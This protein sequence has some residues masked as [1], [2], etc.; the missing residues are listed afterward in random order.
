MTDPLTTQ[1]PS[2]GTV[3]PSDSVEDVSTSKRPKLDSV[4]DGT[5]FFLENL[6]VD[7]H[8]AVPR[9]DSMSPPVT[10][11]D[12]LGIDGPATTDLPSMAGVS[13][14]QQ[15]PAGLNSTPPP[16]STSQPRSLAPS[17]SLLAQPLSQQQSPATSVSPVAKPT[18]PLQ[19]NTLGGGRGGGGLTTSTAGAPL[20]T[21][22]VSTSADPTTA[23]PNIS[24][25]SAT[26]VPYSNM[27]T[28]VS[29]A[30]GTPRMPSA[31]STPFSYN[32][33]SGGMTSVA[34][35]MNLRVGMQPRALVMG[36]Y[37]RHP[38]PSQGMGGAVMPGQQM[39]HSPNMMTQQ[40]RMMTRQRKK[41]HPEV[42][43]GSM[44]STHPQRS[45]GQNVVLPPHSHQV[46]SQMM[47]P[48]ILTQQQ[49]MPVS[50]P[51][52][53]QSHPAQQPC[54][55]SKGV[56]GEE[57]PLPG[58]QMVHSPNMMTQQHRMMTRQRKKMHPEVHGGPMMST[59][60]QQSMGQNAV[61]PPHSHQ[62][63]SQMMAPHM[64]TRQ[65]QMP[66]SNPTPRQSH[67]SQQPCPPSKGVAGEGSPLPGQLGGPQ[68]H[69]AMPPQSQATPTSQQ[70]TPSQQPV[71]GVT[72]L[73][74]QQTP[75]TARPATPQTQIQQHLNALPTSAALQ[76]RS[77]VAMGTAQPVRQPSPSLAAPPQSVTIPQ[78]QTLP[79]QLSVPVQLPTQS[80][81]QV[82]PP[83]PLPPLPPQSS[84]GQQPMLSSL[85]GKG[86]MPG[87]QPTQQ[88]QIG[89]SPHGP[90]GGVN[91]FGAP[92]TSG[93][94]GG[95]NQPATM[96][97]EKRK[98]I[99]QQL[100][101]LLH[102]RYCQQKE[103]EHSMGGG[104]YQP[105]SVLHCQTMKNVLDHMTQCQAGRQ[106]TYDHC[107]SSR[108]IISHW[109]SCRKADCPICLPLRNT[110]LPPSLGTTSQS[111]VPFPVSIPTI[112]TIQTQPWHQS[113]QPELR[114]HLVGKLVENTV[115]IFNPHTLQDPRVNGY[116][117]CAMK[118]EKAMFEMATSREAYY[119]L[120]QS[121]YTASGRSWRRGGR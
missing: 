5:D 45:M 117:Q 104:E 76:W 7:L 47:A 26:A 9:Q 40:H 42:H 59:H 2:A 48:H 69:I 17:V 1:L 100:V 13:Q 28:S 78:Q 3:P 60:P 94:L 91:T 90:G 8:V 50:N 53:R 118:T 23:L 96:D 18:P 12:L 58:Q 114:Q 112:P 29:P 30:M 67:P 101:L 62:V 70:S 93:G 44:M 57:S 4:G 52:P 32:S 35:G 82:M 61:L 71:P 119:Q 73:S 64:M 24:S 116:I 95:A 79:I 15:L 34:A 43:G 81:K 21:T 65:Q 110:V 19:L 115:P 41:M 105:C 51:T 92:P 54:P 77:P 6:P 107:V 103:R 121:L 75:A 84:A 98:L 86:G 22:V 31:S 85:S 113:V 10:S 37:L 106:C 27:A 33:Y 120:L 89:S 80:I 46:S 99:Q 49:Q 20:N 74:S 25:T 97:P 14:P 16:P 108:Q 109:K 87:Q 66:V 68:F 102:A 56:V 11:I 83:H 55:P 111:R 72:P 36:S 63:S 38:G 39:V 88:Q